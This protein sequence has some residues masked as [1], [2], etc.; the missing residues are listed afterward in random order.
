VEVGSPEPSG[1]IEDSVVAERLANLRALTDTTLTQLDVDDLLVELLARLREILEV[2]TAAVLI[3]DERT[4]DLV[5]RAACGIEDEVRQGVRVPLGTGFAGRIAATRQAVRLDRVDSTTVS[6]PLLWEKGIKTMLGVPL[7]RGDKV[8]G[9]LHVGRLRE[10]PFSDDDIEQLLVVG[11]RLT[12]AFETREHAIALAA[13][14]LL[15]RSLSP[16]RLPNCQG[17]E[18]AARY[19]AAEDRSVGGDWY[20]LFTSPAGALWIVVGDVAGHGLES[21]VVMGRVRSALRAY[22][23]IDASPERVLDLVDRKVTHFEIGTMV[24]VACAVLDPPFD[25]MSLAVAGHPPPVIAVPGSQASLAEVDVSPPIGANLGSPRRSTTISVTPGTVVAFYT[26][27]LIERRGESLD[28]GLGRLRGA[29]RP[30]APNSVARDIMR[31][32]LRDVVPRDDI[33]LVVMRRT[34]PAA[35]T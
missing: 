24:T 11:D 20:D 9:V 33:A 34:L 14:A 19:V 16:T 30:G 23:L 28:V 5:A 32:L 26:D 35:A 29:V 12:A 4:G 3:L 6:N 21:A 25:T 2:D 17:V 18:L 27:G 1:V 22:S 8:L 10:R 31:D 15:E 7:V 13:A